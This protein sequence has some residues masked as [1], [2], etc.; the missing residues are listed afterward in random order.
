MACVPKIE[1]AAHRCVCGLRRAGIRCYRTTK[2]CRR[3]P[4]WYVK[5]AHVRSPP[6]GSPP[7]RGLL[8]PQRS[9][10]PH[11][12]VTYG[13]SPCAIKAKIIDTF[14]SAAEMTDLYKAS[15]LNVHPGKIERS[16]YSSYTIAFH[17]KSTESITPPRTSKRSFHQARTCPSL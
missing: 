11:D 16:V 6:S 14:M 12:I 13:G 5:C 7:S 15:V 4:F 8:P 17:P 3:M 9:S 10:A 2:N 1:R